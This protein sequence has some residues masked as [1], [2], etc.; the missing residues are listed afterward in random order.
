[1]RPS[2][3]LLLYNAPLLGDGDAPEALAERGVLESVEAV[4]AVLEA[5]GLDVRRWALTPAAVSGF[6][7]A[8]EGYPPSLV[9]VNLFEGFTLGSDQESA[10]AL[11]L[12]E[13][14]VLYTGNSHGALE[15]CRR[16][17]LCGR[18]L[19][20]AG[21]ATPSEWLLAQEAE[22]LF[23]EDLPWPLIIKPA[24]EDGS[25]GIT[26]RSVVSSFEALRR[27]V[28]E[29]RPF[30]NGSPLLVQE[31]IEGPEFAVSLMGPG[32]LK[33]LAISQM[34]FSGLPEGY[35]PIVSDEA[36]W[37]KESPAYRGT[38]PRCP[39]SLEP[40]LEEALRGVAE[41][42]AEA[43]KLRDYARVDIRLGGGRPVIIDVNPNPDLAPSAGF[44]RSAQAVG[45]EYHELIMRL[46]EY[47]LGRSDG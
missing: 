8:L 2:T 47:A 7:Q 41:A 32:P 1:M 28:A 14:G 31:Y 23:G 34:D 26:R 36:K 39:A 4:G 45:L 33:T 22:E 5:R 11:L 27:Q 38:S 46:L 10:V 21:V 3:A 42:A 35:P 12:E 30:T 13:M 6:V 15:T 40:S 20:A 44:A 25:V 43:L 37:C 16:K 29:T 24:W 19:R 9:V 17:E 18:K